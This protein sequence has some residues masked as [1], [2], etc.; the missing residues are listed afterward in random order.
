[1][2]PYELTSQKNV[3]SNKLIIRKIRHWLGALN[4]RLPFKPKHLLHYLWD[5]Y[6]FTFVNGCLLSLHLRSARYQE[7]KPQWK[8]N[9][10]EIINLP[11]PGFNH[12]LSPSFSIFG[13][14]F[15]ATSPGRAV[16]YSIFPTAKKTTA[17]IGFQ[18]AAFWEHRKHSARV[19][20][21][22]LIVWRHRTNRADRQSVDEVLTT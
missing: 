12:F 6:K 17:N 22:N 10:K 3:V 18:W 15:L 11:H 2:K 19:S 4:S 16:F 20:R 14:S 1:M 7:R 8:F 21:N 5:V 9:L 13:N